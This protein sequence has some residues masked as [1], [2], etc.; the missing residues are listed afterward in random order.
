MLLLQH[1]LPKEMIQYTFA[2]KKARTKL[3]IFCL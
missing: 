1:L 3:Y 2:Y